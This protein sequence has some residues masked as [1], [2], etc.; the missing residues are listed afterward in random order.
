MKLGEFVQTHIESTL[1]VPENEKPDFRFIQSEHYL[2]EV[3]KFSICS[4][5]HSSKET[6]LLNLDIKSTWSHTADCVPIFFIVEESYWLFV[7]LG[8]RTLWKRTH[9]GTFIRYKNWIE[10]CV[11]VFASFI[12]VEGK[13]RFWK[14]ANHAFGRYKSRMEVSFAFVLSHDKSQFLLVQTVNKKALSLPGGK[15]WITEGESPSEC[16]ERE[17]REELGWDSG[18]EKLDEFQVV[19]GR[20]FN[21]FLLH[22]LDSAPPNIDRREVLAYK[23]VNAKDIDRLNVSDLSHKAFEKWRTNIINK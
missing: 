17:I 3:I 18:F 10:A 12:Q 19:E 20:K 21:I 11:P 4:F 2:E 5:V 22:R 6:R 13:E 14:S 7:D 23:W 8:G 1:A 16:L 9:N 15:C